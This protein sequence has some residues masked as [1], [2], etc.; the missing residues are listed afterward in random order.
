MLNK[1]VCFS[2]SPGFKLHSSLHKVNKPQAL[3]R[4]S[5]KEYITWMPHTNNR[6]LVWIFR[7][8][9]K[10]WVI[11]DKK[12]LIQGKSGPR[13]LVSKVIQEPREICSVFNIWTCRRKH[14]CVNHVVTDDGCKS[15][16]EQRHAGGNTFCLLVD[17]FLCQFVRDETQLWGSA[18]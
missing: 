2:A 13:E 12:P 11:A 17:H 14:G 5:K 16:W 1:N 4:C 6:I 15:R 9:T 10:I 18:D 3:A 7:T 8:R